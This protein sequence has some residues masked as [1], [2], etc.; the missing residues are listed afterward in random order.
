MLASLVLASPA[1]AQ[2]STSDQAEISGAP[3]AAQDTDRLVCKYELK[4]GTRFKERMCKSFKE[5]E[6]QREQH[7]R[8]AH[9]MIDTPKIC[10]G[11]GNPE[12]C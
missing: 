1:A 10:G 12:G 6:A 9:E 7:R 4:T 5:W 8:A 3:A 2:G 11:G